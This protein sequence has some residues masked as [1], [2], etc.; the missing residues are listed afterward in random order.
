MFL[1]IINYLTIIMII[2]LL[3]EL[4]VELY[5]ILRLRKVKIGEIFYSPNKYVEAVIINK[6]FYKVT[7]QID[8][9]TYTSSFRD[10]IE[11]YH[12]KIQ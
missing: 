11:Q 5:Y 1:N 4:I 12:N 10:F 7:Y 6:T 9:E 2:M 8:E 3:C